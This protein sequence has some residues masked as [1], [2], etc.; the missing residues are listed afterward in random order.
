M[1]TKLIKTEWKYLWKIFLLLVVAI[2]AATVLGSF[3]GKSFGALA[4]N[5]DGPGQIGNVIFGML[6]LMVFYVLIIASGLGFTVI[7]GV[8][9]YKN[10][11]GNMGYVTNTLP[12]SSRQILWSHILLYGVCNFVLAL[13]MILSTGV[14]SNSIFSGAVAAEMPFDYST[15][16]F[17]SAG[18]GAGVGDSILS[19][20][21]ML[22]SS[23]ASINLLYLAITLGQLFKKHKVFGAVISYVAISFV[24]GVVMML[25][26]IPYMITRVMTMVSDDPF[27]LM[28][29]M[30]WIIF[31]ISG[32]CGA[33][34]YFIV[35]ARMT[36]HLNLE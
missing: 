17:R 22:V 5:E 14:V 1:L 27:V 36:K 15:L 13:G 7:S 32:I 34:A 25:V 6:G 19:I 21:L 30:R 12:V 16:Y 33:I 3:A 11:Y 35:D 10:V 23:L 4:S 18:F 24:M 29:P 31:V 20:L 28:G 26:M 8:R 9:F 2:A